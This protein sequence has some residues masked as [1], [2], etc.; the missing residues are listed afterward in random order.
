MKTPARK[1]EINVGGNTYPCY[2]TL[3]AM[4]LFKQE[5]GKEVSEMRAEN[6]SEMITY[7]WCCAK[8]ASKR[9]GKDFTLPLQDFADCCDLSDLT[10]WNVSLQSQAAGETAEVEDEKKRPSQA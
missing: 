3:G 4:L 6:V 5:A 9:E 2:P 10:A 7:L 8:S 1:I